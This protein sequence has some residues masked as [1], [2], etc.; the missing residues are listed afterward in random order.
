MK[1]NDSVILYLQRFEVNSTTR[2]VDLI[3]KIGDR[4]G[5]QSI[6]G[7]CLV[8]SVNEKTV[9]LPS[10]DF[11]FDAIQEIC[12]WVAADSSTLKKGER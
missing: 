5:F 9:S 6:E 10:E 11:L 12:S 4:L 1:C 3:Q 2:I 7:F 8:A